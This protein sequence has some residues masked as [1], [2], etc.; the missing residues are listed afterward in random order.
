[1]FLFLQ[2]ESQSKVSKAGE[3]TAK[4]ISTIGDTIM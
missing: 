4:G 2:I 3:T 1:M